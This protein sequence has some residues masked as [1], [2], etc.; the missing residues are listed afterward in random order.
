M[1][2][3]L[4]ELCNGLVIGFSFFR[5][6]FQLQ[7]HRSCKQSSHRHTSWIRRVSRPVKATHARRKPEWVR[8]EIIALAHKLPHAG[9]RTLAHC[10]NLQ[11]SYRPNLQ[12][13]PTTVSKTFV[14]SV[15]RTA[16]YACM[17]EH[18]PAG[19]VR[20]EPIQ[21]TWGMDLTGLPLLNA[22]SVPVFGVI[23][24]GSR[25]VLL[26]QPVAKYNSLILLG[27]LLIAMG[28]YGKPR[29]VRSDNDAV[30]KSRL[31]RTILDLL[32]VK[33]QFTELAS[34]WQN[35][36]IERF[37]R[38]LKQ[39][40]QTSPTRALTHGQHTKA[41]MKLV[42]IAAMATLLDAFRYGYNGY[43]PHQSL[44]G[45]TPVI[46]WNAQAN[47]KQRKLPVNHAYALSANKPLY[48]PSIKP[49]P[50]P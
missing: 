47:K 42:S 20:R 36:R 30:F 6:L 14:A 33:Q 34:P 27:K 12:G 35:G 13:R 41:R 5:R 24:H 4:Q 29:A 17:Q 21:T 37:W 39:E 23:D 10:F 44:K 8:E 11:N 40:L 49:K 32:S 9:Y 18:R 25:A 28:T 38:T 16:R 7:Q 45:Q 31:S 19:A 1:T 50:P 43:R 15:L 48:E 26:L 3:W 46:A 2:R 22:G